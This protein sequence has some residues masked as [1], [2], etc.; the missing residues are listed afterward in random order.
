MK[1]TPRLCQIEITLLLTIV[2]ISCSEKEKTDL[3]LGRL[4]QEGNRTALSQLRAKAAK[5]DANAQS[6]LGALLISGTGVPKNEAEAITWLRKAAESGNSDAQGN[7]GYA[8]LEGLGVPKNEAEAVSWLL[9]AAAQGNAYGQHRL[10]LHFQ[11]GWGVE[12]GNESARTN[13]LPSLES[14]LTQPQRREGQ[15]RAAVFK[16]AKAPPS[17]GGNPLQPSTPRSS[18]AEPPPTNDVFNKKAPSAM[19]AAEESFE[20]LRKAAEQGD[21]NA[22]CRL[23]SRYMRVDD[24]QAV[25]WFQRAAEQGNPV[26]QHLLGL[27][28]EAGKGGLAKNEA[29]AVRLWKLSA[30]QGFSEAQHRLGEVY[31]AGR[32]V[33]KDPAQAVIW[34]E[35]AAQQEMA[36]AQVKLGIALEQGNGVAT[37]YV[38]AVKWFRK[39]ALS[40]NAEAQIILCIKYMDDRSLPK[41]PIEAYKWYLLGSS[42]PLGKSSDDASLPELKRIMD[43]N[44]TPAQREEA[45]LRADEFRP[46]REAAATTK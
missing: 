7:M 40:G 35:R 34:F 26:G 12:Q 1:L 8:Y 41:D 45:R 32:G 3:E 31:A 5:G 6:F 25:K 42:K 23:A 18:V 29:E 2:V 9:K 17:A 46:K 30:N 43:A 27:A 33:T 28:Y 21:S 36:E 16:V 14:S 4:A 22:Q 11:Y 15:Q 24:A 44:T 38:Q 37:N 13:D 20:Q 10:G 19:A 39:A